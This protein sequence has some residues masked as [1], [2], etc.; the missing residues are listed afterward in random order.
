MIQAPIFH[1]N[2]DDPEAVVYVAELAIE[3]RQEF[4]RD[5]VIDMFCYRRYGHNEARRAVVHPADHVQGHRQA[6][7]APARST[8]RGS[9]EEG[10]DQQR[11]RSSRSAPT[12]ATSWS[13]PFEAASSFKPNKADWLQGKWAGLRTLTGEEEFRDDPTYASLDLLREV[14]RAHARRRPRASTST[15]RSLRLFDA[16]RK[17]L[18]TGEGVDWAFGEALAFGSLL[19]EGIPVRLSRPGLRPRHLQPAPRRPG[20][21][22]ER[23][24]AT[25]P[26][27]NIATA[28]RASR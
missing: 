13:R 5:V 17:M 1:V 21:S 2:G 28:R 24:S 14:G 15:A 19:V 11:R 23:A 27:N 16:K 25:C 9:I 26:L 20:R 8:P 3:F 6:P 4:E 10:V 7:D 18:E 22:G 12:S